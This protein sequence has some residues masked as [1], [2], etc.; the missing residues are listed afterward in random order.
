MLLELLRY[1]VRYVALMVVALVFAQVMIL[2]LRF[3]EL[4]VSDPRP[5]VTCMT[6]DISTWTE[7]PE[8]S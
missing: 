8:N 3:E 4:G 7:E 2:P 6:L 1:I 5:L